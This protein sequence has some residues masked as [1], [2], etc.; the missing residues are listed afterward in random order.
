[1]RDFI[2]WFFLP[3]V[4]GFTWGFLRTAHGED[5]RPGVG[6]DLLAIQ[7]EEF[8][9]EDLLPLIPDGFIGGNLDWTFGTRLT[10][11]KKVLDTGK[12]I[13]WRVHFFNGPGLRNGQLGRYE[14]HAGMTIKS[15]NA[16]WEA[17]GGK[18]RRHL[19]D[20][21]RLYCQLLEGYPAVALEMSPTL[22]H[23]LTSRAFR[24]QAAV[25]REN[26]PRA[27][28]VD[29]PVGGVRST[30]GFKIERHGTAVKGLKA[31]C[32]V[33]LDGDEALDANIPAYLASNPNC[34]R[35]LWTHKFN[36]RLTK[37]SFVD[38]RKRK[39]WPTPQIFRTLLAYARPLPYMPL[40]DGCIPIRSPHLWKVSAD[41]HGT[42]DIRANKPLWISPRS[43]SQALVLTALG[44][45]RIGTLDYYG[46][47][48]GGGIRYY[49]GLG[50]GLYG[51][52]MT[53]KS[54]TLSGSP[55][56]VIKEDGGRCFGPF[57]PHHRHGYFR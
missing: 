52:E 50:S 45:L 37:G 39:A 40:A 7:H 1:M 15:F 53:E 13:Q 17:G 25:I 28:I 9:V 35:Y 30:P 6:Q 14:P 19:R 20:R 8:P 26:C 57:A 38:P 16:A 41:D 29:N 32:N 36:G 56:V 24:K 33:S 43:F 22:E 23:N 51:I 2:R 31:P 47:F 11:V 10:P 55:Y 3:F 54:E 46:P 12:V 27:V 21:V 44:R 34:T 49:S 18:L 42:G 48:D 4:F 5:L